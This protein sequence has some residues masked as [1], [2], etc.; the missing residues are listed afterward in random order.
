MGRFCNS[1]FDVCRLSIFNVA[2]FTA[3]KFEDEIRLSCQE[4][5]D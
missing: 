5:P 1:I 4:V 3:Q 2:I